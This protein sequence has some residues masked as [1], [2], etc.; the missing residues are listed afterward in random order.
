MEYT[1]PKCKT[2]LS[3]PDKLLKQSKSK[4]HC[5]KCGTVINPTEKTPETPIDGKK[6]AKII[7]QLLNNDLN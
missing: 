1:C 6:M 2:R 4:L 5:L 3:I 7:R